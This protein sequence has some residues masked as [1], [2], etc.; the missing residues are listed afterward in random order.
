[1]GPPLLRSDVNV[2]NKT[3]SP[4]MD[5]PN[6]VEYADYFWGL[7][8]TDS[9]WKFND[10]VTQVQ[11][12][13]SLIHQTISKC[14]LTNG[15][16]FNRHQQYQLLVRY[17]VKRPQITPCSDSKCHKWGFLFKIP[18]CRGRFP[19]FITPRLGQLD[20]WGRGEA[21][22]ILYTTK[23]DT[24]QDMI[25]KLASKLKETNRKNYV[26]DSEL[27]EIQKPEFK[28]LLDLFHTL[29]S[30]DPIYERNRIRDAAYKCE[31]LYFTTTENRNTAVINGTPPIEMIEAVYENQGGEKYYEY[32]DITKKVIP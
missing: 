28:A 10:I 6:I 18:L 29:K 5:W 13:G 4:G 32:C 17:S 9:F 7:Y 20:L 30:D 26:E 23:N 1:M 2:L 3:V 12:G 25:N 16:D 8:M 15:K 11:S 24:V 14:N 27:M 31:Q 19:A 21:S 22:R